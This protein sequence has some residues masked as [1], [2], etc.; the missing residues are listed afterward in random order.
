MALVTQI[1]DLNA[2][3]KQKAEV[4]K[5]NEEVK[6]SILDMKKAADSLRGAGSP[7]QDK[8]A[9]DDLQKTNAKLIDQQKLL[10]EQTQKLADMQKK[11]ADAQK[12]L[13]DASG[14][15]GNSQRDQANK[16]SSLTENGKLL[17]EALLKVKKQ[18]EEI[19][20][21]GKANTEEGQKLQKQVEVL[22][23]LT[24]QQAKGFTSLAAELR[25]GERALQ[26]MREAGLAGTKEFKTMQLQVSATKREFNEFNQVQK[27]L[28][29]EIPIIS[30]LTIAVRGLGGAYAIGAGAAAIFGDEEG[31]IHKEVQKLIAV[32]T[33]LQGISEAH[34][35][36][37]K[38]KAIATVI[39]IELQKVY[40]FVIGE[41]TGALK[42]FRIALAATGVGL[43]ILGL[44]YLISKLTDTKDKTDK[45][46]MSEKDLAEQGQKLNEILK[47]QNELLG[48]GFIG[49]ALKDRVEALKTEIEHSEKLGTTQEVLFAKKKQL[50]ALEKQMAIEYAQQ[51]AGQQGARAEDVA[52]ADKTMKALLEKQSSFQ[53]QLNGLLEEQKNVGLSENQKKSVDAQVQ[54]VQSALDNIIP[55]IEGLRNANKTVNNTMAEETKFSADEQRKIV[56]ETTKINAETIIDANNRVLSSDRTTLHQRLEALRSNAE[57]QKRIA[58]ATLS[59]V[60]ND[61]T[62]GN[63]DRLIAQ[64]QYASEIKKI[65]ADSAR[66]QFEETSKFRLRDLEAQKSI[67]EQQKDLIIDNNKSLASETNLSLQQRLA[68]LET[69][70]QA[71]KEVYD[72]EYQLKLQQAGFSDKEIQR[73]AETGQFE[74]KNKTK[75]ADEIR[76]IQIEHDNQ[77]VKNTADTVAARVDIIRSG[78]QKE[79]DLLNEEIAEIQNFAQQ[80]DVDASKQYSDDV[81]ALNDSLLKKTVSYEAYQK[82]RLKLDN[83][84]QKSTLDSH[85]KTLQSQLLLFKDAETKE[86]QAKAAVEKLKQD[87]AKATTNEEKKR[88][89]NEL[90]I[91]Q[92]DLSISRNIVKEKKKAEEEITKY[93]KEQSDQRVKIDEDEQKK[94]LAKLAAFIQAGG[95]AMSNLFS[96][97]TVVNEREKQRIEEKE[98]ADQT[99]Y[100]KQVQNIEKSTLSQV[101]KETQ[102]K[103]LQADKEAHE[104][105]YER[106]KRQIALQQARFDKASNLT[107]AITSGALAVAKALPNLALAILVGIASGAAIAKIA[108]TPLPSYYTGVKS[109]PGGMAWTDEHGPE[110]YKLPSGKMF[111]G[112]NRPTLRFVERGTEIVP[113]HKVNDH[114]HKMAVE[115]GGM[116]P[117]KS[118]TNDYG[119]QM[120]IHSL[121]HSINHQ[122]QEMKRVFEKQKAPRVII[123]NH[124][125]WHS[126]L[127]KNVYD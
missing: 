91:A 100:D 34:E 39:N 114:I 78:L 71:Q 37:E 112:N 113:H 76:A 59:N 103:K 49:G 75:T 67:F 79:K 121:E 99:A 14:K 115:A 23:V 48:T 122:T 18:L 15:A 20:Q 31:K 24:N 42:A 63:A 94:K 3:E 54:F 8:K 119:T 95:A 6:S 11:L 40:T 74:I 60:L 68:A 53:L 44:G 84:Y 70:S 38:R 1:W 12:Q 90:K 110:L 77:I 109:A 32:M 36:L 118:S 27:L 35:L 7:S 22:T 2:L 125:D 29:S 117:S 41:T 83:D 66:E 51:V 4:I 108:A 92:D 104:E 55:A 56:F 123:H 101:E 105:Q 86:V 13:S 98:K 81:I 30:G 5:M 57:E 87:L 124:G 106:R 52:D 47:K 102:L 62:K 72:Q 96:L 16:M 9:S 19:T 88:I 25:N 82:K 64:K 10:A 107:S 33:V 61:P 97:G 111:L 85:I 120:A 69:Y 80:S 28:S 21:A 73:F 89:L 93:Q 45:L 127:K 46:A 58:Q 65:N 50:A 116:L 17:Y 126:Y 26:T 43:L